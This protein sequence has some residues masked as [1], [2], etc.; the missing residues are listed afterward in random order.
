VKDL[1]PLDSDRPPHKVIQTD[2]IHVFS[3]FVL[4]KKFDWL[5]RNTDDIT[6]QSHSLFIC[7]H[8][9]KRQVENGLYCKTSGK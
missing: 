5:T 4:L 2:E 1:C 8:E 7:S 9:K 3:F 6:T